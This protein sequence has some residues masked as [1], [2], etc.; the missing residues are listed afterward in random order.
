MA[1]Q[2]K[3]TSFSADV[4]NYIAE[5]VL[6]LA[7]RQLVAYQFADKLHLPKNMGTTYTASR[8]SRLNLPFAQLSEGVAS[9][10]ETLTLTQSTGTAQQWGDSVYITDVAELTITHDLFQQ[11]IKL[12]ALQLGETLERNAYTGSN[13]LMAG[14]NVNYATGAASRAALVAGNVMTPHEINRA[15]GALTTVG[16]PRFEGHSEEDNKVGAASLKKAGPAHYVSIC[17]PLVTQD[18]AENTT[19]STAWSY[20]DIDRLYNSEVGAWRGIRPARSSPARG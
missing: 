7:Q 3:S 10:G 8:Y 12:T 6:P 14:S 16:A 9:V 4:A 13:G 2:N 20:S 15:V 1:V 19:I 5:K 18:L 11:G 17:H